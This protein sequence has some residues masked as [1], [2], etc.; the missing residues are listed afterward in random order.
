[1]K[2]PEPVP[3]AP[4]PNF[5][6]IGAMKSGTTSLYHYLRAHP[7][8]YMPELKEVDFFTTELNWGKGWRWY[9]RQFEDPPMEATALG[10]ASTSYTKHPRYPGVSE[11]I[12]GYLPEAKLIYVVRNPIDRMRSHYQHNVALGDERAPIDEA[13]LT[14]P[15]YLDCSRYSM[16]LERYLEH[17]ERDRILIFSSEDLRHYREQTMRK[18]LA[19]LDV[20]PDV[21][22]NTLN[23]EFYRT[24]ERAAVPAPVAA[25]RRGLKRTFPRAVGLW[26]GRFV[27]DGVKRRLGRKVGSD[28]VASTTIGDAARAKLEAELRP[29]VARLVELEPSL[30]GWSLI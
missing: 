23:E 26:R 8:V 18:V 25:L 24:E 22:L 6:V 7:Q 28:A 29:D 16:Q 4:L 15:A 14:N 5:L 13:L 3:G 27:P 21:R 10:E 2:D 1:M 20:D 19:F 11:R 30:D 9:H 17:F 12:A